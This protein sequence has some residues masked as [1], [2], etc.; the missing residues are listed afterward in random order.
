MGCHNF[1]HFY[2]SIDECQDPL[3]QKEPNTHEQMQK[4][5]AFLQKQPYANKK[6]AYARKMQ[7]A[8]KISKKRDI[9]IKKSL[10]MISHVSSSGL[11]KPTEKTALAVDQVVRFMRERQVNSKTKAPTGREHPSKHSGLPRAP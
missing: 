1:R 8:K 3:W 9:K 7:Q 5:R 4:S 6:E 10:K 11:S 2:S